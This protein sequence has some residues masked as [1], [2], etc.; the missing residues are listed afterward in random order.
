M[1][2]AVSVQRP[3]EPGRWA[4]IT[5]LGVAMAAFWAVVIDAVIY[6]LAIDLDP[7]RFGA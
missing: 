6:A 4:D 7:Q 5:W 3:P 2:D 1:T